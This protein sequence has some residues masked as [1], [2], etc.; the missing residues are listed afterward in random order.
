LQVNRNV[1]FLDLRGNN[2]L[3]SVSAAITSAAAAPATTS[4]LGIRVHSGRLAGLPD[5]VTG[6]AGDDQQEQDPYQAALL[7]F[8]AGRRF[9]AGVV[10]N[11]DAMDFREILQVCGCGFRRHSDRI[12]SS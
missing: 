5:R 6:D 10:G 2:G 11:P 8:T 1:G 12:R 3:G 4:A 9:G 7:W